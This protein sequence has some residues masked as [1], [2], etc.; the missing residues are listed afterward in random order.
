MLRSVQLILKKSDNV[1][2]AN[3]RPLDSEQEAIWSYWADFFQP[4]SEEQSLTLPMLE[5][6][7]LDFSD[8]GLLHLNA[9]RIRVCNLFPCHSLRNV[10]SLDC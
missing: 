3:A 2:T 10:L 9:N 6:V 7:H 8:W 5:V 4:S 1:C